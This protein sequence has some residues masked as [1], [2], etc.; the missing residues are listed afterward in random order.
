VQ[1][2]S[3][4]AAAAVRRKLSRLARQEPPPQTAAGY[5]DHFTGIIGTCVTAIS[6]AKNISAAAAQLSWATRFGRIRMAKQ[7]EIAVRVLGV[8]WFLILALAVG[9]HVVV[10]AEAMGIADFSPRG[11]P[12][13][14]S[15]GCLLL[16]YLALSC[17]MLLRVPPTA[18]STSIFP[19]MI[20]FVGTYLPWTIV[21]FAPRE[22]SISQSI[23]SAML[24]LIGTA[25]MVVVICHLGAS[26]SIVPQARA[27]VR[28]GP[29]SVIRN[30]L[31]LVEEVALLGTLLQYYS[32]VTLVLFVAHCAL[33]VRRM[34]YEENLL[35]AS[36]ADYA[37][38]AK[39]TP[40]LIPYVW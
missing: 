13:L 36:F 15:S 8:A 7:S 17:M 19:S 38:Y 3:F 2:E 26:F 37:D 39:S 20:A 25:S 23:V 28:T 12:A 29:Y 18:R 1:L 11:W 6:P 27:L 10:H 33:Q 21:L 5:R 22:A 24:C 30:P 40:R 35:R 14:L 9:R 32:P 16:F 4:A 31:Y 34:L